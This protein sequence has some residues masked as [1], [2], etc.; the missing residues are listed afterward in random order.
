MK[1]VYFFCTCSMKVKLNDQENKMTLL[2]NV[3][4]WV[5]GFAY[6]NMMIAK[7]ITSYSEK[8]I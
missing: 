2:F 4:H 8:N 1:I 3:C 6:F 5:F 7:G